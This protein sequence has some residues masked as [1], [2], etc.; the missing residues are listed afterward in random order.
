M[1]KYIVDFID[2]ATDQQIQDW[3]AETNCSIGQTFDNFR[4]TYLVNSSVPLVMSDLLESLIEDDASEIQLLATPTFVLNTDDDNNWWKTVIFRDAINDETATP[5]MLRRG[6]GY[7]VYLMDSGVN[8]THEDFANTSVRHLFS[9]SSTTT[10]LNGH[11]T[12]LASLISGTVAGI[13]SAEI[14]SVKIFENG[15]PTL[16]SHLLAALDAVANDYIAN[17]LNKPMVVNMSWVINKNEYVENKIR[18]LID[19]GLLVVAAA[20]NS[21]M[22]ISNITPAGMPEV[23]TIG[24][25]NT[26]L[27]P[28]NFSNYTG[29]SSVSYTAGATNYAPG[30][31]YWAPGEHI[32]AAN[33]DGGYSVIA[34]TSAAAA[35][36]SAA[37]IYN[38][39]KLAV[40]FGKSYESFNGLSLSIDTQTMVTVDRT[41]LKEE[42]QNTAVHNILM[43]SRILITL[44]PLYSDCPYSVPCVDGIYTDTILT[45]AE[46]F[47]AEKKNW[48][49]N[50]FIVRKNVPVAWILLD[51]DQVDTFTVDSLPPGL[52]L[53]GNTIVGTM[54]EDVGIDKHKVYTSMLNMTRAGVTTSSPFSIVYVD[55]SLITDTFTA[56]DYQ[57]LISD[58]NSGIVLAV[59]CVTCFDGPVICIQP[60]GP[61]LPCTPDKTTGRACLD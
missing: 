46:S 35:I 9:H 30:L 59:T 18:V 54:T 37:I 42:V 27:D 23:T 58:S 49:T 50:W 14:V 53:N 51:Q 39:A 12:A 4:K 34:G 10:D 45:M 25:V 38:F 22:P 56:L 3:L 19:L 40:E 13:T 41:S 24:S 26:A 43:P 6:A 44:P 20:G 60:C 36:F 31:D 52:S 33:K 5:T 47:A 48:Y 61:L 15:T 29:G 1:K 21:G 32:Y 16:I 57:T 11:G 2:T 8:D 7:S 28:S 17:Y 55:N